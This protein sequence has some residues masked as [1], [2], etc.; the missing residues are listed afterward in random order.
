MVNKIEIEG[1]LTNDPTLKKVAKFGLAIHETKDKSFFL[2]CIAFDE[3][4]AQNIIK[5]LHK[6]QRVWVSGRL[7]INEW[8]EKKYTQIIL[9]KFEIRQNAKT[10]KEEND[11]EIKDEALPNL[12][13]KYADINIT[14]DD[15]PF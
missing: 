6:G 15:L 10:P 3:E 1:I 13:D 9:N 5:E 14:N 8:N 11:V 7:S 4:L 2:D 12:D